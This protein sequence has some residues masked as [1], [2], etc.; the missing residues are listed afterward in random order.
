E[1]ALG[2]L[3]RLADF[4][5]AVGC[6][7]K[8]RLEPAQLAFHLPDARKQ[9]AD[10]AAR[11][12][13]G[14]AVWVVVGALAGG[15]GQ[16]AERDAERHRSDGRR[17]HNERKQAAADD[18]GLP[19]GGARAHG[20]VPARPVTHGGDC[21]P[22]PQWLSSTNNAHWPMNLAHPLHPPNAIGVT[23]ADLLT[24]RPGG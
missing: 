14:E 22:Y 8:S 16:K 18:G 4:P 1:K 11:G 2:A 19:H 15:A 10:G 3:F 23:V 21:R 24:L 9:D 13:D 6:F 12:A 5:I 20:P 17:A 7:I